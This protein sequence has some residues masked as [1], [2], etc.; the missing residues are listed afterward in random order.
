VIFNFA[1]KYFWFDPRIQIHLS[2]PYEKWLAYRSTVYSSIFPLSS[3]FEP[4]S[5][6][7]ASSHRSLGSEQRTP[8][9]ANRVPPEEDRQPLHYTRSSPLIQRPRRQ[10]RTDRT[11]ESDRLSHR[12][13]HSSPPDRTRESDR[14]SHR[15]YHSSP[16]N[17]PDGTRIAS[18][19][20][21]VSSQSRGGDLQGTRRETLQRDRTRD[22]ER[23][24]TSAPSRHSNRR[25][26][27]E[28]LFND[29]DRSYQ[30]ADSYHS[31]PGSRRSRSR[32]E[33]WNRPARTRSKFSDK[34]TWTGSRTTFREYRQA[35]EGHLLQAGAGYLID[36]DFLE[37]YELHKATHQHMDY[38][39][40]DDF[41]VRYEVPFE[42]AK[43]DKSYLYGIL[44]G[45]GRK[46]ANMVIL[47]NKPDQDGIAAWIQMT[48]LYDNGGSIE[49]R[50]DAIDVCLRKPFS[51]DYPGGLTGYVEQ[52][53]ALMAEL[54][55]IAPTY[56]PDSRKQSILLKNIRCIPG[57][58]HL[59]QHCKDNF[60]SYE[61][62]ADYLT[63]NAIIMDEDNAAHK[64]KHIMTVNESIEEPGW[65]NIEETSLLFAT[66]A[67]DT[68]A[69]R[70][71]QAFNSRTLRKPLRIPDD[72]WHV[73]EPV[74][75][76]QIDTI[77]SKFRT[78]REV[79]TT[80]DTGSK[81]AGTGGNPTQYTNR[82][83][84]N[85]VENVASQAK[86]KATSM[87][88]NLTSIHFEIDD[89]DFLDRRVFAIDTSNDEP[90][91]PNNHT[92]P[93]TRNYAFSDSGADSCSLGKHCHPVSYTGRHVVLTGYDEKRSGK[94]PIITAY[95]K[96]MSQLNIPVILQIH[97]AAYVKDSNVTLISEY[98][99]RENGIA[100][101]SVS[102][103]HKTV[104][105]TFGTQ[106]MILS[107]HVYVPFVDKG[108]LLGYEILPWK[109][110]DEYVYD[111]FTITNATPWK[112][113]QFSYDA[114]IDVTATII[115]TPSETTATSEAVSNCN[116]KA[117]CFKSCNP[118]KYSQL[119]TPPMISEAY[120]PTHRGAH[121]CGPGIYT[122]FEC[123]KRN[124]GS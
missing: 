34:V 102:K 33:P 35:I 71:Y 123:G 12:S 93:A 14:L 112:P 95:I 58:A 101:D 109:E 26:G 98:Q 80:P 4:P 88:Q 50:A 63:Q 57:M 103:R 87:M 23:G 61:M 76:K 91:T 99:V 40:S 49:S 54:D 86:A 32:L 38:L 97:E 62:T 46:A 115:V 96:V 67:N 13:Y 77:R 83:E 9:T 20:A 119:Y 1:V 113:R 85:P 30:T 25:E 105:G 121:E 5:M 64:P 16:P 116:E 107:E 124:Q 106:R 8:P 66:I 68:S 75:K 44:V 41:W 53:Q 36:P 43:N 48:R 56:Y 27:G 79:K 122:P 11:P 100:I 10:R 84:V 52:Y 69:F 72:I 74:I 94:T 24:S 118:S 70:A 28:E 110:G 120:I 90:A 15:S 22:W 108:G 82:K 45:S 19:V 92:R 6:S 55:S 29:D 18:S 51:H 114:D 37:E 7:H 65:L 2:I 31:Q 73:L 117:N 21:P 60:L 111:V 42:Q 59:A 17:L 39:K 78:E 3:D 47:K 89:D 104:N 81:T